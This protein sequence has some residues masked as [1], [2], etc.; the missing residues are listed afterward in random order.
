MEE[1]QN[2]PTTELQAIE[3]KVFTRTSTG[4]PV[5]TTTTTT[6]TIITVTPTTTT[7]LTRECRWATRGRSTPMELMITPR[8]TPSQTVDI[9]IETVLVR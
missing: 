1:V 8:T 5:V 4:L 2:R 3:L 6:T 7:D 9:T